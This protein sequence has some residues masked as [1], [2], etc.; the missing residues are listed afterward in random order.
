MMG[1]RRVSGKEYE[2]LGAKYQ[3]VFARKA[4]LEYQLT[5]LKE[6]TEYMRKQDAEIKSLHQNVRQLKHDMKNHF[7]VIAS[8]LNEENYGMAKEYISQ[9]LG[10]LNAMHSYVE[11]GNSLLNH[12][13]NEKL[14]YA[15]KQGISVK[16]EIENL[17]FENLKSIDFSA[18]LSNM[19]DN[20]IEA[21]VSEIHPE[22]QITIKQSRGYETI[23]VKN[24]IAKS[25]LEQNPELS[26]SKED[27]TGHGF[28][29]S[30]IKRIVET[31][32]GM[33][34]FYEE[35][36]YFCVNVFIPQ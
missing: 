1:I 3:E 12:I 24:R 23:Y 29:V 21:S 30:K 18:L 16:A 33:Y 14:E 10:K 34:D 19:L 22:V 4:E 6:E 7:M 5:E 13:L 25:V 36:G 32:G 15:K 17:A 8:Y 35:E 2:E 31:C 28:G 26:T 9:M 27:N 11:T 20:A